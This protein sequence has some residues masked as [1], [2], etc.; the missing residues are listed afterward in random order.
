MRC[1]T[2]HNAGRWIGVVLGWL[3]LAHDAEGQWSQKVFDKPDVLLPDRVA[4]MYIQSAPITVPGGGLL[5][6]RPT[7][8]L[9]VA[10]APG[11]DR[12]RLTLGMSSTLLLSGGEIK[13]TDN[14]DFAEI[15]RVRV[16][17]DGEESFHSFFQTTGNYKQ[18]TT[19][20]SALTARMVNGKRLAVEL[21]EMGSPPKGLVFSLEGYQQAY[22]LLND[23]CA[24]GR[25]MNRLPEVRTT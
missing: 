4:A 13:L 23:R 3:L 22:A 8:Q 25:P 14:G 20:T 24:A 12:M 9:A 18:L 16:A 15:Y 1:R 6:E 7:A 11:S 5:G 21:K 10:C 2:K 19:V 17:V